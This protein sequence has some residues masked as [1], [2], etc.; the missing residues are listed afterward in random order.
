MLLNY[1]VWHCTSQ[2]STLNFTRC[3]PITRLTWPVI[4][5]WHRTVDALKMNLVFFGAL[6]EYHALIMSKS[7]VKVCLPS[8]QA[9]TANVAPQMDFW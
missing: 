3:E 6:H 4:L 7:E 2:Q 9:V 1:T 5:T 8:S